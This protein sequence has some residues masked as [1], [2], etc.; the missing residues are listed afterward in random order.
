MILAEKCG[1][2]TAYIGQIEIGN[3]FP[4]FDMVEKIALALEIKPHLLFLDESNEI[5]EKLSEKK[6]TISD[7]T[8]E[9]LINDITLAVQKIIKRIN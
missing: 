3:R 2:S 1:T 4:S 5:I 6:Q 9:K 8:K 7:F